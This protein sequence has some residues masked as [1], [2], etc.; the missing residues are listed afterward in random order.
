MDSAKRMLAAVIIIG[1]GGRVTFAQVSDV[2]RLMPTPALSPAKSGLEKSPNAAGLPVSNMIGPEFFASRGA[3]ALREVQ[4]HVDEF[5]RITSS[6][7]AAKETA[8]KK[9]ALLLT[10][11]TRRA[12]YL[13]DLR[14]GFHCSACGMVLS[15]VGPS[16]FWAHIDGINRKAVPANEQEIK[17]ANDKFD[18]ERTSLESEEAQLL[19]KAKALETELNGAG[20]ATEKASVAWYASMREEARARSERWDRLVSDL[21]ESF[22]FLKKQIAENELTIR[23]QSGA[24]DNGT[25]GTL[26]TAEEV[27]SKA[28]E[29]N[30]IRENAQRQLDSLSRKYQEALELRD[31]E[32]KDVRSRFNT[33][34]VAVNDALRQTDRL[35]IGGPAKMLPFD[36]KFKVGS[37]GPGVPSGSV[38]IGPTGLEVS[39]GLG[40]LSWGL[41]AKTDL[42]T[43]RSE[44]DAYYSLKGFSVGIRQTTTANGQQ[45]VE[46]LLMGNPVTTPRTSRIEQL[47]PPI[48]V[49]PSQPK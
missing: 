38:A 3:D 2:Q 16:V 32:E 25:S 31:S 30:A 17:A 20:D 1:G 28:S 19:Q 24:S 33:G 43:G 10:F 21:G 34:L 48:V 4:Q 36:M 42:L 11:E 8:A 13:A 29:M 7:S 22:Q 49:P 6:I 23:G 39:G 44:L 35:V 40:V 18:S 27:L 37:I 46:P 41:K 5:K 26:M 47:M 9:R 14:A 45:S 12:A 15:D